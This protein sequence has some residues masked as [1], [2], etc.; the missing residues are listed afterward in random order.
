VLTLVA[1]F[2]AAPHGEALTVAASMMPALAA[3]FAYSRGV[4]T[5]ISGLNRAA[6]ESVSEFGAVL[7]YS[8]PV[9]RQG[10]RCRC[11]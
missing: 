5:L 11:P 8:R 10:T 9:I 7:P 2:C 3:W 4:R 1:F 6:A